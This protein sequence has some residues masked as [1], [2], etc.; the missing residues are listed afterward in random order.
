[1]AALRKKVIA[2]QRVERP[3]GKC[4]LSPFGLLY[5]KITISC[6]NEFDVKTSISGKKDRVTHSGVIVETED[7]KKYL[8]HKGINYGSEG[9]RTIVQYLSTGDDKVYHYIG[10]SIKPKKLR[11]VQ[12]YVKVSGGNYDF[13]KDNCHNGTTKMVK[14]AKTP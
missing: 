11:E 1:M 3:L 2:V 13:L 4:L 6:L 8:I 5:G 7:H 9:K 14:L 12:E 10:S